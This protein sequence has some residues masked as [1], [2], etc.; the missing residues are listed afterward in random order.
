MR[1]RGE[2]E[3]SGL[4]AQETWIGSEGE[5]VESENGRID[6]ETII[7]CSQIQGQSLLSFAPFLV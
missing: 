5:S 7:I 2:E 4:S 1:Y 6:D 3:L